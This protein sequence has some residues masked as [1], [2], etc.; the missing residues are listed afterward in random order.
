MRLNFLCWLSSWWVLFGKSFDTVGADVTMVT[1]VA[2]AIARGS[3]LLLLPLNF[4]V[5]V[6]TRSDMLKVILWLVVAVLRCGGDAS[7]WW[8]CSVVVA[9][10]RCFN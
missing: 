10:L 7:L 5:V 2:P 3:G 8:R 1:I 6:V 4:G 9:V